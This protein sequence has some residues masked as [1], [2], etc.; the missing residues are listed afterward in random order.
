MISRALLFFVTLSAVVTLA[1][2]C[3]VKVGKPETVASIP[4]TKDE[5]AAAVKSL[6]GFLS[7]LDNDRGESWEDLAEILKASVTKFTWKATLAG[8]KV[9]FGKNLSRGH[10][11]FACTDKIPGAPAGRYFIFDIESKFERAGVAERVVLAREGDGWKV[12]G[13]FRKKSIVFGNEEKTP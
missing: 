2:G 10:A 1:P 7:D 6:Q 5:Q 9:A 13:Y 12:A 8:F 3:K 4:Y 11:Q